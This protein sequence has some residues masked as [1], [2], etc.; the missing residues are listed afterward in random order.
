MFNSPTHKSQS[1]T[2]AMLSLRRYTGNISRYSLC[3]T[4]HS[5]GPYT[6]THRLQPHL[7]FLAQY[8]TTQSPWCMPSFFLLTLD[9]LHC[10]LGFLFRVDRTK[11]FFSTRKWEKKSSNK[12]STSSSGT[13]DCLSDFS[14]L[15]V[16]EESHEWAVPLMLI[17]SMCSWSDW[18]VKLEWSPLLMEWVAVLLTGLRY[19]LEQILTGTDAL[20]ET[21][22]GLCRKIPV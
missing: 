9:L 12:Y 15:W 7:L 10:N 5:A 22:F 11:Q 6:L 13:F 20:S 17:T 4:W 18:T 14:R 16:S 8:S 3:H 21:I 1:L 19:W 2:A